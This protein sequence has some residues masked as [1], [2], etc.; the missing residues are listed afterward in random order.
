VFACPSQECHGLNTIAGH[1]QSNI[2]VSFAEGFLGQS[3]VTRTVFDQENLQGL[4]C[5]AKL[6]EVR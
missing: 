6:H 4:A 5:G 3:D 2:P 1:V